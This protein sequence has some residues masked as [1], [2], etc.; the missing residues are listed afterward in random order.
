MNEDQRSMDLLLADHL[1]DMR[2]LAEIYRIESTNGY[3]TYV[4]SF[5]TES[6]HRLQLCHQGVEKRL[7]ALKNENGHLGALSWWGLKEGDLS[8]LD[9]MDARRSCGTEYPH[10]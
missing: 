10:E 9:G 1:T 8:E 2:D 6:D 5:R 7:K 3:G 4:F